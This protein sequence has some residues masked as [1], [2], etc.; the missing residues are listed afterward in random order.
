M[1]KNL[2]SPKGFMM[3]QELSD[4]VHDSLGGKINMW[5]SNIAVGAVFKAIRKALLSGKRVNILNVGVLYPSH[6]KE[7][8]VTSRGEKITVPAH[9]TIRF[10]QSKSLKDELKNMDYDGE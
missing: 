9:G 8:T 2:M 6:K 10:R 4:A 1:T 3:K 7:C 5:D